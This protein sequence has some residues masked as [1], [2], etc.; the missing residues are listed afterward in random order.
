MSRFCSRASV[1]KGSIRLESQPSQISCLNTRVSPCSFD[2]PITSLCPFHVIDGGYIKALLRR[3]YS[4]R[5]QHIIQELGLE[6]S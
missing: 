2:L 4:C 6:T 3:A 1:F 5:P